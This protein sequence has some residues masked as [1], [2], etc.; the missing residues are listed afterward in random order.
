[1]DPDAGRIVD[2]GD[3]RRRPNVHRQLSDP[4]CAVG[5]PGKG[6]LDEDRADPRRVEGRRDDVRREAI[7]E[8]TPIVQLDLLDRRVADGLQR[9]ALDLAL[10]EDWVDH[11]TDVVDGDSVANRD[12]AAVEIDI[13][14]GHAR[15]PTEGRV[16]IATI[17]VVVE[18]DVGIRLELLVDP[19][20][21]MGGG[22]VAVD[23]DE[24]PTAV[25]GL[26]L[27]SQPA[28]GLD[29]QPTDDHRRAAGD[30]RP[31]VRDEGGVLRRDL[32]CFIRES[33]LRRDQLRK[34]RLCA[35][36]HLRRAGQDPD[37]AV[38]AEL[39]RRD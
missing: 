16:G 26:D 13:D 9:P 1:M 17:G 2:R 19:R 33:E 21:A 3:D 24:W 11:P 14:G 18:M 6:R 36:A 30:R 35:L 4:L 12:L 23:G 34:D 27:V 10:G 20:R 29:Q 28:G 25:P 31:G 8:V 5:R 15:G 7:V 37:A 38:G 39:E 22:V 32:D